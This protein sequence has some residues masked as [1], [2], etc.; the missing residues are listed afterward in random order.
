MI[1]SCFI[2]LEI[3]QELFVTPKSAKVKLL[4]II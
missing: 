3:N 1:G 2:N 4:F